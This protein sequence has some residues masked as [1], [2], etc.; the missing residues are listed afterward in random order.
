MPQ[1]AWTAGI[2]Q[3]WLA[4]SDTPPLPPCSAGM[5]SILTPFN[6]DV[7]TLA[8]TPE[9]IAPEFSQPGSATDGAKAGEWAAGV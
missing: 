4:L 8:G 7:S 9:F 5:A 3:L 2:R 1:P 6:G